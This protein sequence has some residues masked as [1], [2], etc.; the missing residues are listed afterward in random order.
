MGRKNQAVARKNRRLDRRIPGQPRLSTPVS[1][2]RPAL[3]DLVIPQGKCHQSR[4][5]KYIF[6]E[7][8]AQRALEQARL[9][10]REGQRT[11]ERYYACPTGGCGG[12]HLTSRAEYKA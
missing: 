10:R 3:E 6:T 4:K 7:T 1:P 9:A 11:E 8:E 5:G 2:R 12:F